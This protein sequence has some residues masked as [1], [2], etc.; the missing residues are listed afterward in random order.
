MR[1]F[2]YALFMLLL[3][4]TTSLAFTD[5]KAIITVLDF[6]TDSF[7]KQ[8]MTSII[9]L[10][11]SALFKT[12]KFTVIDVTER[13]NL[14]K[15]LEFSVSD[16]SDESCQ[17]EIG[18]MLAAEMIVVGSLSQVGSKT[19]LTSKILETGTGRTL[20][21]ADGIYDDVDLLVDDIFGFAQELAGLEREEGSGDD[22]DAEV[23]DDDTGG[24]EVKEVKPLFKRPLFIAG[25]VAAGVGGYLLYDAFIFNQGPV[26]D[27]W[28]DYDN[29]GSGDDFDVLYDYYEG[30][31]MEF[32]QKLMLGGAV[33]GV[34][35]ALA[36]VSV[37]I[38]TRA[39]AKAERPSK[40]SFAGY[41]DY[42]GRPGLSLIYRY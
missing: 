2:K 12:G 18:K 19:I 4:I 5:D 27:A 8:E 9:S 30:K 31:R 17:L 22:A 28:E 3:C 40:M 25:I 39:K 7:S 38:H 24:G 21:T 35:V 36:A 34:G 33:T 26:S 32:M 6:K 37:S 11:S 41:T 1:F 15:E 29:A 23:V 42:A 13:D 10:L 20:H 14:L 16:C